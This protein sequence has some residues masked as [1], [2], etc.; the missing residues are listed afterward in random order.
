LQKALDGEMRLRELEQDQRYTELFSISRK[1]EGLN[2]HSSLH[3][4]GVVIG[5]SSIHNLVPIFKDPKTGIIATQFDMNHLENCGLVKMD[6]LGLKTLDV[7]KHTEE[8]IRDRGGDYAAFSVESCPEDDETT[9]RMLSE[10]QSF[11]IF[12]FESSGMQDTLKRAKPGKVED[13]IALNALYRPGPMANIPRFIDSKNGRQ[14]IT[15]P[16][17]SLEDVLKETY[18]VIVY[19]EQVM[20]V[21]R[22]I[23]GYSMGQ[24]DLLRRAM[25]KKKKEI[26]DKEKIPFLD[27]AARQGFS[28]DRAGKIYDILVP[29]GDYGFNKSHA[30]CY[31]V[32]AYRTA[33]LKANF[34]AEFMAASLTNEIRSADKDKLSEC[35]A[36]ARKLGLAIDPPDINRS[37]KLFNI[38]DGR[39][40]YGLLGI[41]GLG[42]GPAEEIVNSRN[43]GPYLSFMDFLDRVDIK[44]IGKSVIERLIQTGAFDN[45]DIPR[46]T[47]LGNFERAAEY[48]QNIKDE[49]KYGQGS[50]FGDTG[51][52]E[53]P[54]FGFEDFPEA[55]R[56][57]KLKIEKELIG[58]YFS[59][60]P[61]DE[62]QSLW[63]KLVKVNL[64]LPETL[65]SGSQILIGLIKNIKPITTSKGGKMAF[66]SL[67]D[68][69]G[70]IELTFFSGAWEKCRDKIEN[71]KVAILKGKIDY[72]V[73]KDKRSF[74]VDECIEAE[75]AAETSKEADAQSRKWDKYR[76][77]LNYAPALNLHLPN[78]AEPEK[79]K[80]GTYTLIGVLKSLKPH[81]DKNGK[82]MAF[83]TIQN[84]EGEIDLVFFSRSWENCK[85]IA[86]VDEILAL[87]GTID[88][89]AGKAAEKPNFMVSGIQDINK[90]VRSAAKIAAGPAAAPNTAGLKTELTYN[91]IHIRLKPQA[92]NNGD[93]LYSLKEYLEVNPGSC[94]VYIHVPA[95]NSGETIIRARGRINAGAH[96]P[97][98][99]LAKCDAVTDVWGEG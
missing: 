71:D 4:S 55:A 9:F 37:L 54:D 89:K 50:L 78:L 80:A 22:I 19:Q 44:A 42:D 69:N 59:G 32:L 73:N 98:G 82:E 95:E 76:K 63:Q 53:F 96:D 36:E 30:T 13:L 77:I 20:Q 65:V 90:L 94:P 15:Y 5:K 35:I 28:A 45:L 91:K 57:D 56:A 93:V 86:A 24:A 75:E 16:D 14:A 87:K 67:E 31:A 2:R 48:A 39:I 8:L 97:I 23:A 25:G 92:L 29:F 38:V 26:I 17:P 79:I 47:L 52:K 61:M 74:L 11:E 51:E 46:E 27:G 7:I 6:F 1:L 21:A 18:G 81:V 3:A 41:K 72:Q 40:V 68:Y 64:S 33:Y 99:A 66:A 62:Y 58:F 83:G 34:P 85:A 43:S 88:F 70:E 60:H 49:K 84:P 10:G 12:Q